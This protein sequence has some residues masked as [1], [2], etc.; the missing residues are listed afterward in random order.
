MDLFL[1]ESVRDLRRNSGNVEILNVVV[2]VVVVDCVFAGRLD[3]TNRRVLEDGY[4]A[5]LGAYRY[6]LA[7]LALAACSCGVRRGLPSAG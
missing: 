1:R 7:L 6:L 3:D 2:G 5:E 4:V